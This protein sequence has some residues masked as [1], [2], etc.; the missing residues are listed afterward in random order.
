MKIITKDVSNVWL[1]V[2][3]SI[4]SMPFLLLSAFAI[5]WAAFY[6]QNKVVEAINVPISNKASLHIFLTPMFLF[7][8]LRHFSEIAD[9]ILSVPI[10]RL[11]VFGKALQ[12]K[13]EDLKA[14][15]RYFCFTFVVLIFGVIVSIIPPYVGALFYLSGASRET[16]AAVTHV[17]RVLELC[18][19][20]YICGRG[21]LLYPRLALGDKFSIAEAVRLT[22]GHLFEILCVLIISTLIPQYLADW[23][24]EALLKDLSPPLFI[25]LSVQAASKTVALVIAAACLARMYERFGRIGGASFTYIHQ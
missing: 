7:P 5:T 11:I 9:S 4:R 10:I 8:V 13:T 24:V 16:G 25:S 1:N 23:G 14:I 12:L 2:V 22:R 18:L 20:A 17:A 6:I 15:V 19:V 21:I 3:R